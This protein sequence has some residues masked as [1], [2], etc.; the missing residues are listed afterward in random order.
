MGNGIGTWTKVFVIPELELIRK[1]LDTVDEGLVQRQA[2]ARESSEEREKDLI[3]KC[4][5]WA[6]DI[7]ANEMHRLHVDFPSMAYNS[8]FVLAYSFLE[9]ELC[10]VCDLIQNQQ[11]Y[12]LG[13]RDLKATGI[14]AA[15]KCLEK[16]C[17]V[18]FP[19]NGAWKEIENL[20]KVRNSIVHANGYIG[21]GPTWD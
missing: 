6:D 16:Q 5:V 17:R 19:Q 14:H 2:E 8:T 7:I 20:A 18:A 4:G 3:S 21:S 15:R 1:Y 9:R 13:Y 11:G 10:I 12:A